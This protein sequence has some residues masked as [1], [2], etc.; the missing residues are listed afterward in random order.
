MKVYLAGMFST[1]L[2]RRK[3]AE[4][5]KAAGLEVTSRWL[6]ERVKPTVTIKEVQDEYLAETAIIDLQDILAAD[7]VVFFVP[8]DT[9]L[10]D[11]PVRSAARGGRHF[12]MGYAYAISKPIFVVGGRENVFHF[13]PSTNI[14]HFETLE[15]VI[16]FLT[17]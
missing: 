9:E 14:Q 6:E 12:E 4:M 1:Q 15:A 10:V 7:A 13:L 17:K 11:V 8:S 16:N 3:D 5:L 2:Q